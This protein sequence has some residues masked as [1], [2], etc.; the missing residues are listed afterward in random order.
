[1]RSES[2]VVGDIDEE[3]DGGLGIDKPRESR[4]FFTVESLVLFGL[5]LLFKL[6]Q[7]KQKN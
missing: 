6:K 2:F 4:I 3:G 7:K 5:G 1:L